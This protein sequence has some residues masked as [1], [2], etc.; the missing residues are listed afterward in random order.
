MLALRAFGVRVND[1]PPSSLDDLLTPE[2][3]ASPLGF[4]LSNPTSRGIWWRSIRKWKIPFYRIGPRTIRFRK[5][6]IDAWL[7]KR[8]VG[9][10]GIA[11]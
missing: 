6:E 10:K 8:R 11:A 4:D 5:S 9:P 2:Q 3:V 7:S 1:A